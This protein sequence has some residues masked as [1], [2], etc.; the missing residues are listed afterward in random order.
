MSVTAALAQVHARMEEIDARGAE[1]RAAKILDGLQ[2]TS[3][4]MQQATRTFSGGWRMRVALAQ[5]LFC[6]PDVL[7]LDEPTNH[8]D[9]H[10]VLWLE[11]YLINWGGT[12]VIVSH[13]REFLNAV[14]TDIVHL[15]HAQLVPYKGNFSEFMATRAEHLAN[16][17]PEP[18]SPNPNPGHRTRTLVT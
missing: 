2:F 18:W 13:A 16:Q 8:L 5:A 12:I 1:A 15:H 17:V 9:L 6:E 3:E 10:A 11:E 7:L 14:C 4:D